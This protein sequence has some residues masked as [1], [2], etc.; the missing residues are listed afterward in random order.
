MVTEEEEEEERTTKEF[1]PDL[2]FCS[3]SGQSRQQTKQEMNS[4]STLP[5]RR[6]ASWPPLSS[7]MSQSLNLALTPLHS[8]SLI[9][10]TNSNMVNVLRLS[11]ATWNH[12]DMKSNRQTT[13][14]KK[15]ITDVSDWL[16]VGSG[17]NVGVGIMNKLKE[18]MNNTG[19]WNFSRN[20]MIML[21]VVVSLPQEERNVGKFGKMN[22]C[23][24][25]RSKERGRRRG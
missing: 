24:I 17:T 8:S 11:L 3:I 25:S 21:V 14:M 10:L 15:S 6:R 2:T 22:D 5:L 4:S 20:M 1:D 18:G 19:G 13:K 12:S 16:W 7:P 9:Y 23:S